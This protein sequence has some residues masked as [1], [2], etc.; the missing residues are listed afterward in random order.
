M[1]V[2]TVKQEVDGTSTGK[3]MGTSG[4]SVEKFRGSDENSPSGP[5]AGA[6][7]NQRHQ[8]RHGN[9]H[10]KQVSEA[11]DNV[12]GVWTQRKADRNEVCTE[13]SLRLSRNVFSRELKIE[14]MDYNR[15]WWQKDRRKTTACICMVGMDLLVLTY[16]SG[17][18]IRR[19]LQVQIQNRNWKGITTQVIHYG[20][21]RF[22]AQSAQKFGTIGLLF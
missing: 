3:M 1:T 13:R 6:A 16:S 20:R 12:D 21:A 22:C 9:G 17:A 4:S 18:M 11:G 5:S 19:W 8:V 15:N 10:G 14:K 2:K 7:F